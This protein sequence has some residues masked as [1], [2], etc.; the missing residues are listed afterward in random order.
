MEWKCMGL[1]SGMD[2][3]TVLYLEDVHTQHNNIS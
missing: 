2:F 3:I 1:A